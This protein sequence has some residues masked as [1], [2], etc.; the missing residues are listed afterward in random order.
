MFPE[1]IRT[2]GRTRRCR[3]LTCHVRCI[4]VVDKVDSQHFTSC[5]VNDVVMARRNVC[6]LKPFVQVKSHRQQAQT[7]FLNRLPFHNNLQVCRNQIVSVF[8]SRNVKGLRIRHRAST[9]GKFAR[10]LFIELFFLNNC[11]YIYICK[12]VTSTPALA[13]T[14]AAC[15]NRYASR[16]ER[17]H[18]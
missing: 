5:I 15:H 11:I 1:V 3:P 2:H 9:F 7:H 10:C 4:H 16:S 8:F 13:S 6:L 17:Q 18:A 12:L 14:A